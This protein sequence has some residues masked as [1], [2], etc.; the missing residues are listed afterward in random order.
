ARVLAVAE[1][2]GGD[3]AVDEVEVLAVGVE[4][5]LALRLRA[6]AGRA[7]VHHARG[8]VDALGKR[9][10]ARVEAVHQLLVVLGDH[11][12]AAAVGAVEL[13]HLDVELG[14]DHRHRAVQLGSEPA[15]DAAG[16]VGDLDAH[17][18]SSGS[19]SP[20][21]TMYRFNSIRS[22]RDSTSLKMRRTWLWSGSLWWI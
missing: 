11:A 19:L 10:R 8:A 7:D 4:P 12:G 6:L 2:L 15:R 16:P 3:V 14:G 1:P 21:P 9:E 13:H 5:L 20:S 17:S 18:S 22:P